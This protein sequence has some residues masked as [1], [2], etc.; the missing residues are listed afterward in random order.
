MD[1][2]HDPFD[3]GDLV[4]AGTLGLIGAVD[5]YDPGREAKFETF[6]SRRIR[7]AMLDDLR[8]MDWVPRLT[9][10][11]MRQV[12]RAAEPLQAALGRKPTEEE[13]ADRM[14]VSPQKLR[15]CLREAHV[16]ESISLDHEFTERDSGQG[17]LREVDFIKSDRE[18]DP[19]A[20]A[21]RDDVRDFVM[22]ELNR[23]E[24]VVV[25]M[26]YCEEMTMKE[27]GGALDL[28]ESRV[29]QILTKI[30]GSLRELMGVTQ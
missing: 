27:I 11:R 28:S 17:L 23:T 14:A 22:G 6:G 26:Y 2:S 16:P 9:R 12:R 15:K 3:L 8:A 21:T 19:D 25:L 5:T 30:M 24:R 1:I 13:L 29:C 7:G 4:S 20:K 10:S 18:E